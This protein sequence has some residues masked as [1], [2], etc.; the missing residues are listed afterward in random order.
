M[1]I[2]EI[3]ICILSSGVAAF[4]LAV[5][6]YRQMARGRILKVGEGGAGAPCGYFLRRLSEASDRCQPYLERLRFVREDERTDRLIV[7]AG[8]DGVIDSKKYSC[9]RILL[10]LVLPVPA[11]FVIP[12]NKILCVIVGALFGW[13]YLAMK[14]SGLAKKRREQVELELPNVLD[15]LA[16]SVEAGLDFMQA[17]LRISERIKRG[18]LKEEMARLFATLNIGTTRAEA[19]RL[20]SARLQI[21]AIASFVSLLIQADRLGVGIAPVLRT[22]SNR[23]RAER[24]IRAEKKGILAAQKALLPVTF[25]IM[26]VTFIVVFGP[27]VVR[28]WVYGLEGLFK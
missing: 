11:M 17:I 26:P 21:P 3:T 7:A 6:F 18:P 5:L 13:S 20:F 12:L 28:L 8:L 14:L 16:T 2:L 27:L 19:L 9:M 15:W 25:C 24:L 1:G 22:T 4:A 10:S 23:L